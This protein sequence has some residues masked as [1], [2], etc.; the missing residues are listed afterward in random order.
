MDT[1]QKMKNIVRLIAFFVLST[2]LVSQSVVDVAKKEQERREKLKGKN[3]K[4][5]TNADLKSVKRAPA[6]TI[7]PAPPAEAAVA[8][9]EEAELPGAEQAERAYDGGSGSPFATEILPDTSMVENPDFALGSPDG[10]YAEISLFGILE[11]EFAAKNGEGPDIVVHARVAGLEEM[12]Q[13]QEEGMP[14]GFAG[15]LQP[16]IPPMYG[17]LV[18]DDRGVWQAIGKDTGSGS[19][20]SFDLGSIASSKRIRIIYQFLDV[21]DVG[22][23]GAKLLRMSEKEIT[24]GIDAVEALH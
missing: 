13:S 24:M 16:G 4:V 5:V 11:L 21:P 15:A 20:G 8:E 6:V 12:A 18:L 3:A 7:P 17:V 23:Q 2:F 1:G 19:P 22:T 10:Q 9:A 14:A